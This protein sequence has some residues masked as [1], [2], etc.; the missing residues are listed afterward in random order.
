MNASMI[1]RLSALFLTAGAA[2]VVLEG[3]AT[4]GGFLFR[5][6]GHGQQAVV[7]VQ[8]VQTHAVTVVPAAASFQHL[9]F[10]PATQLQLGA[11]PAVQMLQMPATGLTTSPQAT[12][13]VIQGAANP[14]ASPGRGGL[15]VGGAGDLTDYDYNVLSANIGNS[16]TRVRGFEKFI[17]AEVDKL[18]GQGGLGQNQIE[19]LAFDA[20]E[21]FLSGFVP[22]PIIKGLEPIIDKFIKKAVQDRK[23]RQAGGDARAPGETPANPAG[24]V[25]PVVPAG[26][27][28]FNVTGQI[29]LTPV[30]AGAAVN[31]DGGGGGAGNSGGA[32]TD[33][34]APDSK[35]LTPDEPGLDTPPPPPA[36]R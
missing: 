11:A 4:A 32:K 7:F 21:T 3:S 6:H 5:G 13:Y 33:Q 16:Q 36:P 29:T 1:R 31:G 34:P 28:T 27:M 9:T 12:Y 18:F 15:T 8:P 24:P 14:A 2:P 35:A 17:A 25:S 10:A 23:G 26:G 20:A 22:E 30:K 19:T